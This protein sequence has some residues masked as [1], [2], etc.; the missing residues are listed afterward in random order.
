[1]GNL[2]H[3]NQ[4]L[5]SRLRGEANNVHAHAYAYDDNDNDDTA[6]I[7]TAANLTLLTEAVLPSHRILLASTIAGRVAFVLQLHRVEWV[8][9][10]DALVEAQL[11]R[12]GYRVFLYANNNHNSNVKNK[13]NNK[14]EDESSIVS[15]LGVELLSS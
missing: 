1:M 11:T 10:F 3:Q 12:F 13:N 14:N 6:N 9:D 4:A 5:L 15:A 8:L 2:E 7:S